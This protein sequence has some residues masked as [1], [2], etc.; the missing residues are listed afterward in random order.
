MKIFNKRNKDRKE[1]RKQASFKKLPL[2]LCKACPWGTDRP[3]GP[4]RKVG[5]DFESFRS[6]DKRRR[7]EEGIE[8]HRRNRRQVSGRWR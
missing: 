8:R 6:K 7:E 1:G 4:E 2:H 3:W 5:P